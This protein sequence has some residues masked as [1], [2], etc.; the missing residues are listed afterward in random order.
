MTKL[1]VRYNNDMNTI[2]FRN[3]TSTE[4]DLFFTICAN[5][6]EKGTDALV[7]DFDKLRELSNYEPTSLTR[8]KEDL[9]KT[10]KKLLELNI[11]LDY[12]NG[13][14]TRFA[15]FNEYTVDPNTKTVTIQVH[16]KFK[17][18]L[19]DLKIG[20]FTRFE[21]QEFTSINSTY[22]KTMYRL[23]KQ[24]KS[25]GR[26]EVSLEELKKILQIPN[27]YKMGNIDQQ[28]LNP[29]MKD[30]RQ[31]FIGLTVSKLDVKGKLSGKGR[32]VKTLRFTFQQQ[33]DSISKISSDKI[34]YGVHNNVYLSEKEI[35]TIVYDWH[36]KYLIDEVSEWKLKNPSDYNNRDFDLIAK[37][38]DK[39]MRN[40]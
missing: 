30:L 40:Y 24:W 17:Y 4:L 9:D 39:Q 12:E 29:I 34:T 1:A 6:K 36:V 33:D 32:P 28:I 25:T 7:F 14:Y 2:P 15:L 3:F 22:S 26:W 5:L 13:A 8:F 35:H 19:N 10:Y 27:S 23:L 18:I 38:K 37:F 11:R 20:N 31:F 16:D 21:L